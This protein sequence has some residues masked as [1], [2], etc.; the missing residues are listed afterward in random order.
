[1]TQDK[2]ER[3]VMFASLFLLIVFVGLKLFVSSIARAKPAPDSAAA[4]ATGF[5]LY[6][7]RS[8]RKEACRE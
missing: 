4:T 5:L 3:H 7:V 1:M 8:V 6:Q 2:T